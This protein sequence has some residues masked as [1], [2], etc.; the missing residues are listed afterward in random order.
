MLM[1]SFVMNTLPDRNVF[2]ESLAAE[3]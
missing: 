3:P 1:Y 2:L